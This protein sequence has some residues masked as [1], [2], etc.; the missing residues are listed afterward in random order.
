MN[1]TALRAEIERKHREAIAAL[2]ALVGYLGD[3]EGKPRRGRPKGSGKLRPATVCKA[4]GEEF[5]PKNA[6][7]GVFC[8]RACHS[9]YASRSKG[10]TALKVIELW[11]AGKQLQEI[12]DECP[13]SR[14][15]INQILHK[16][17]GQGLVPNPPDLASRRYRSKAA[18]PAFSTCKHCG[19]QIEGAGRVFC[20]M[21]CHSAWS[22]EHPSKW[23]RHGVLT[24]TCDGCGKVFER[25]HY[26][27][28]VSRVAGA[29]KNY[30][31]RTCFLNRGMRPF[32]SRNG[33]TEATAASPGVTPD[34]PLPQGS[35]SQGVD[36]RNGHPGADSGPDEPG[37][38]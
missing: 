2:D 5:R 27:Q 1:I 14:Q 21:K 20:T 31:D 38:D 12:I 25:S 19:S 11:N 28:N 24:L 34:H 6:S 15:R 3:E 16:A 29:K 32:G 35:V 13:V 36:S 7:A 30:C 26:Q 9:E 22:R 18:V 10:E 23:S 17:H 4:C 33:P 8:G 37:G